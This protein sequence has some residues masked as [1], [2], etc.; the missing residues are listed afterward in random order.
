MKPVNNS[1]SYQ[2]NNNRKV[3]IAGMKIRKKNFKVLLPVGLSLKNEYLIFNSFYRG[4]FLFDLN[5]V[6]VHMYWDIKTKKTS[7]HYSFIMNNEHYGLVCSL[8]LFKSNLS[9]ITRSRIQLFLLFSLVSYRG[10][11][12]IYYFFRFLLKVRVQHE[13]FQFLEK[14]TKFETFLGIP[15]RCFR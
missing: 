12:V 6:D 14:G 8:K 10:R 9:K 3:S 5:K 1:L 4:A 11:I 7:F 2:K 13:W 15:P